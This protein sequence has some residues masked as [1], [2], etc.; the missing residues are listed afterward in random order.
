MT[1]VSELKKLRSRVNLAPHF[2]H[3]FFHLSGQQQESL[4]PAPYS[5]FSNTTSGMVCALLYP[6]SLSIK[7]GPYPGMEI[8]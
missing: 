3:P 5:S 8:F 4:L 7:Y 1:G 6:I 2:P